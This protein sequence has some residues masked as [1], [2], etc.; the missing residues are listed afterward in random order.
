MGALHG[1]HEIDGLVRGLYETREAPTKIRLWG[2][3]GTTDQPHRPGCV[4]HFP[5]TFALLCRITQRDLLTPGLDNTCILKSR[6]QGLGCPPHHAPTRFLS[7]SLSHSLASLSLS[8][9]RLLFTRSALLSVYWSIS[10]QSRCC[11]QER[12]EV[13]RPPPL[14]STCKSKEIWNRCA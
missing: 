9:S 4:H 11:Q 8:L 12:Q 14:S 5:V 10:A 7:L 13:P 2:Q 6:P 3:E 1:R